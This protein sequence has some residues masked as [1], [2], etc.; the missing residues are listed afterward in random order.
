[1]SP[2]LMLLD[3]P[4][5][6]LDPLTRDRLQQSFID[7]RRRFGLTAVLVTHDIY[8]AVTICSRVIWIDRGRVLFD[9]DSS[10]AVKAY[11]NSIR[12][13][14][15]SRLRARKR[16][17]LREVDVGRHVL[18]E[19][20]GHGGR[21]T[22]A[23]VYFSAIELLAGGQVIGRLPL[24]EPVS[25][26]VSRAHLQSEGSAWGGVTEWRGRTARPMLNYGSPFHKVA[27]VFP[28]E[29]AVLDAAPLALAVESTSDSSCALAVRAYAGER[30]LEAALDVES[31]G[32][33]RTEVRL[34]PPSAS[35]LD[36]AAVNVTG[37]H[38]TGR[39][40]VR[41][42]AFLDANGEETFILEHGRPAALHID[43]R[44]VDPSLPRDVQVVVAWQRNGVQDICRF[45]AGDIRLEGGEGTVR[46]A[47]DRLGITDG[48]YGIT[49]M[50]TEPGYYDRQQTTFFAV[51]P[52]VHCCLSRFFD[53]EVVNAGLIGSGT[54]VVAEGAW[55]VQQG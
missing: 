19:I 41:N 36:A 53:V 44:I 35:R 22:A 23:P 24:G 13:Q 33:A 3:E 7:L 21:P 52:G 12:L 50:V 18:V 4:F 46:L 11:E 8:S 26:D 6:A 5:G 40:I 2:R 1:V 29:A 49:I 43:Y 32:W 51:N 31:H 28:V 55:S 25:D 47:I 37:V 34:Q 38:G 30:Q 17:R 45:F 39:V 54:M 27:G 9:G 48:E 20:A 15:E 16:E 42:A 10:L 14:E